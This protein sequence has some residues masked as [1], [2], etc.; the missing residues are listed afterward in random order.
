M[1][2]KIN[3]LSINGRIRMIRNE[4]SMTQE[5]LSNI[6]GIGKSAL[7]MIETGRAALSERNRNILIQQL[8]INPEGIYST[9]NDPNRLSFVTATTPFH[10]KA[11][12]YITL[13]EQPASFRCFSTK[14]HKIRSTTFIFRTFLNAMVQSISSVT[15]CTLY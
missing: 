4:L 5:E 14:R 11:Y 1:Q 13:R 10:R 6:L 12:H 3:E 7:S 15:A 2:K 8:N 9:N